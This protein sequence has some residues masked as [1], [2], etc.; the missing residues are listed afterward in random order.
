MGWYCGA[1]VIGLIRCESLPPSLAL[2]TIYNNNNNNNI[3]NN[4]VYIGLTRIVILTCMNQH[5][6]NGVILEHMSAHHD[7]ATGSLDEKKTDL[8]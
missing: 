6:Q 4:N 5:R 7:I 3:N 1:G 8:N 2:L